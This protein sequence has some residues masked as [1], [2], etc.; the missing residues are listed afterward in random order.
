MT[1]QQLVDHAAIFKLSP[2]EFTEFDTEEQT[3]LNS[4]VASLLSGEIAPKQNET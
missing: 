3:R 2:N 4:F 1:I